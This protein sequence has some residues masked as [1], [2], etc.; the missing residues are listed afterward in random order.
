M[1][2]ESKGILTI[3]L[4]LGVALFLI[5]L[6]IGF[7]IGIVWIILKLIKYMFF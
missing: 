5:L 4:Y 2:D 7:I 1:K 3:I 6:K